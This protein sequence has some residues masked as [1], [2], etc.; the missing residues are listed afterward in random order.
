MPN[1]GFAN[2]MATCHRSN[3]GDGFA[4]ILRPSHSLTHSSYEIHSCTKD[5][6]QLTPSKFHGAAVHALA[7]TE[8]LI[9]RFGPRLAGS[10][11]CW[12]AA[13]YLQQNWQVVCGRAELEPFTAHPTAFMGSLQLSALVYFAS[14]GF[15]HLKIPLLAAIGFLLA[16]MICLFEFV[17]YKQFIDYLF[18]K[19]QCVNLIAHLEP[20]E[21]TRQ[22]IILSGHHDS[23]QESGLLRR[24][25]KFGPLSGTVR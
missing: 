24:W 21:D 3:Y 13:R 12:R 7:T 17:F 8:D 9:N 15:L 18:P 4:A 10:E 6:T 19:K 20:E 1:V 5:A 25:Q 11:S 23:A 14:V 16:E 2:R 22:Q